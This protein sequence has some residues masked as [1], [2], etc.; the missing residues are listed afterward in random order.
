MNI[1]EK[2]K[3]K[4]PTEMSDEELKEASDFAQNEVKEW[5]DFRNVLTTEQD[6]RKIAS[7]AHDFHADVTSPCAYG[8]HTVDY[9]ESKGEG[10]PAHWVERCD[11]PSDENCGPAFYRENETPEHFISICSKCNLIEKGIEKA[12]KA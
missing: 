8:W 4:I 10:L 9:I 5:H 6:T 11:A 3:G 2:L 1:L 12:V 7:C